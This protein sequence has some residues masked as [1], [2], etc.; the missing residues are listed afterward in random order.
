MSAHT[1]QT[2]ESGMAVVPFAMSCTRKLLLP[3][4][5]S[6]AEHPGSPDETINKIQVRTNRVTRTFKDIIGYQQG[7]LND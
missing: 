7:G 4:K 6:P 1:L 5:S 2:I 3:Q